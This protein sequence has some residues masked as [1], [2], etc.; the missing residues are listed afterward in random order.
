[1]RLIDDWRTVLRKAWSVKFNVAAT[2]FGAAEVAV[3]IWKPDGVPNGM[4]AGGAAA[5]SIF[6]N[7]SRLLAQKEIHGTDK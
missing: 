4:F 5:I 7:V 6:A 1:M 2:L 3:A